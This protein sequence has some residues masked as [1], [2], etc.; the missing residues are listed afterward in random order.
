MRPSIF[1]S[2]R[3]VVAVYSKEIR[4]TGWTAW[5]VCKSIFTRKKLSL[6]FALL[7]VA[8]SFALEFHHPA[9]ET[10]LLGVATS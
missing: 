3:T 5:E 6:T 10:Q 1:F 8:I 7:L 4:A 2:Q 9:P